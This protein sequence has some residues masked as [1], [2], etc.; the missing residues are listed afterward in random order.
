MRTSMDL[1]ERSGTGVQPARNDGKAV[2]ASR[3][4]LHLPRAY[5]KGMNRRTALQNLGAAGALF[6]IPV[7]SAA[8]QN[9]LPPAD[10][11][12]KDADAYWT[13]VRD[14]QFLLA[15]WRA[16]LNNG[17]LGVAPR[18]VVQAV[19][20]YME[21]GAALTQDEYPRWG[22]ETLDKHRELLAS[23]AGCTK[24]E[25]AIMH[26]AT[27]AMSTIAAGLDLKAG[28]EVLITDQ[29]HPSGKGCWYLRQARHGIKVREVK[30]PMPPPKPEAL[31][32]LLVSAITPNT[33][34]LS[35]SG[36]LTTTGLV[37]PVREIW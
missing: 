29:E 1:I 8:K 20:A 31:A 14:E 26:S 19:G 13:R 23:F 12:A 17:S 16:Y 7:A 34:V 4:L 30:I 33:R 28:D 9:P 36:I 3:S 11:R 6:G 37:M 25:L 2:R 35:F 24:N 10:L 21:L 5:S 27:E 32:D 22:Y 15:G 18:P